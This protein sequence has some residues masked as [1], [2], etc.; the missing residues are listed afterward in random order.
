M[1]IRVQSSKPRGQRVF[2]SYN[3]PFSITIIRKP[4]EEFWWFNYETGE[5][6]Q[7]LDGTHH[8][9]NSYFIAD[10]YGHKSIY[11]LKAAIRKIKKWN[12]PSGT[13]FRI[14]TSW[15][16]YEFIITKY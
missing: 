1:M 16:G 5:W 8:F 15:A 7:K 9:S 3:S 12:L 13:R 2:R 4:H 10:R 14:C 6:T 11:S